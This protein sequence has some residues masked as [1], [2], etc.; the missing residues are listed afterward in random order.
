[1][2]VQAVESMVKAE[3]L[4][5]TGGRVNNDRHYGSNLAVLHKS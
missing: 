5:I 1:M 2:I 4:S 3:H